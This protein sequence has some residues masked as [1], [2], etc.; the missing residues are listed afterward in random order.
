MMERGDFSEAPERRKRKGAFLPSGCT[1][2]FITIAHMHSLQFSY[3]SII[4]LWCLFSVELL[5]FSELFCDHWE[6]KGRNLSQKMSVLRGTWVLQ[7]SSGFE[8]ELQKSDS[9]LDSRFVCN[10]VSSSKMCNILSCLSCSSYINIK[11][12]FWVIK[13]WEISLYCVI[14]N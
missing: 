7:N 1:R 3:C 4:L 6:F 10:P 9:C 11:P 8:T 14:V 12:L 2:L 5:Q 13:Q